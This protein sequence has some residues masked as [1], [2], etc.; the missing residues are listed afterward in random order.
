MKF[1]KLPTNEKQRLKALHAYQI[2]DPLP[3]EDYDN[4][5]RIASMIC[6]TPISLITLIDDKRQWFKSSH[7]LEMS[8]T[9]R[10][11]AYCSHAL[12]RPNEPMVV[13]NALKDE[14]FFD[15]PLATE[16]PQV[17]FYAGIPLVNSDGFALGALCVMDHKP[18]EISD[19]QLAVLKSLSNQVVKLL[20]LRKTKLTLK[21]TQLQLEITNENLKEFAYV[22]AH[23]LKEPLRHIKQ[24]AEALSEDYPEKLGENGRYYV[25]LLQEASKNS[26]DFVTKVLG[27]SKATHAL[28]TTQ[29]AIDLHK[30]LSDLINAL[31]PSGNIDIRLPDQLPHIRTSAVALHQIFTNL[32]SNA[33]KYND[34]PQKWINIEFEEQ[35]YHYAF[36]ISD[37]GNGIPKDKL[38]S[39]FSL[40]YTVN[41]E[42]AKRKGSSG[43]GLS[44]V[45]KLV[46][47]LGG[48]IKV[49]SKIGQG[50]SFSFL[51]KK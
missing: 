9:P 23:D 17:I 15:N 50:T 11:I 49:V 25:K 48:R 16:S 38:D 22:V 20:E 2:L 1:A 19:E 41:Q 34:K 7:G 18:R 10:N 14:R 36:K 42:D 37:N 29:N 26:I 40:F 31:H 32:L 47:S 6:Q 24:F 35:N 39:I 27:Y 13:N 8:E 44:I 33:I 3:E 21:K 4:I 43:I 12:L 46:N 28:E 45:K 30:F 5:T 51:L